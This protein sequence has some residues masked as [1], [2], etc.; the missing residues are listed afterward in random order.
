MLLY[1]VLN[2]LLVL[3]RICLL[4]LE[5]N[6]ALSVT[7]NTQIESQPKKKQRTGKKK[8]VASS[9]LSYPSALFG[10]IKELLDTE[11]RKGMDCI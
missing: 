5:Y 3:Y 6:S 11:E 10:K 2:L 7:S 9:F 1:F 4:I 8:S